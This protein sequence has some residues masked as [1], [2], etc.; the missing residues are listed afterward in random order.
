MYDEE[1]DRQSQLAAKER[2][3]KKRKK[4]SATVTSA[5]RRQK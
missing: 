4:V 1:L 3:G 2:E 5:Q